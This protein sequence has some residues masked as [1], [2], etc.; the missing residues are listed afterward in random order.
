MGKDG[1]YSCSRNLLAVAGTAA[2]LLFPAGACAAVA[3]GDLVI[4]DARAFGGG[5]LLLVDPTTGSE[6]VISSNAMAVN[7]SSRY[8]DLPFTFVIG[9]RDVL[10]VANTGNLGGSCNGGCGGVLAVDPETGAERIVSSNAMAV[11]AASQYFH[12][13]TGIAEGPEGDLYVADWGSCKGCGEVIRVD[14]ATGKETLVSSNSM[15]VNAS[16]QLFEYVQAIVVE[17]NGEIL[18]TDPLAFGGHGG[19]VGVDPTTGK[20]SEFSSNNLPVNSSSQYFEGTGQMS[21]E[22]DGNILVADWCPTSSCGGIVRVDAATGKETLVASNSMPA[23]SSSQYF[24]QLTDV[25]LDGNRLVVT[26]EGGLGGSCEGG[27]GGVLYVDLSTGAETE[28]SANSLAVNA[29]SELFAQPFDVAVVGSST[30]GVGAGGAGAGGAGGSGGSAGGSGSSGGSGGAEGA[31]T[32]GRKSSTGPGVSAVSETRGTIH[33][34]GRRRA[35]STVL[36]FTLSEAASVRITFVRHSSHACRRSG[37]RTRRS[38]SSVGL[39]RTLALVGRAGENRV[40]VTSRL[41]GGKTL[42]AGRYELTISA[43]GS[44]GSTAD[45]DVLALVVR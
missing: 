5:A 23:N 39:A 38:C 30:S 10:Y 4:A 19:I 21:V 15:A 43:N 14:P 25:A 32:A 18:V 7:A 17:R 26:Q 1:W 37:R 16:S 29:T 40:S 2:S 45:A 3:P 44:S 34:H 8:F 13:P 12:E 11:N 36:S 9:P 33:R 41:A 42:P 6:S 27:C 28:L 20:E 24:N 35:R 22:A 31:A